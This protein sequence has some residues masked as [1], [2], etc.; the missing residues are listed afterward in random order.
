M[1]WRDSMTLIYFVV[2]A[3]IFAVIGW[4]TLSPAIKWAAPAVALGF[5]SVGLGVNSLVLVNHTDR[6]IETMNEALKSIKQ[7]QEEI[8]KEQKEQSS[9]SSKIVPTLQAFS[10][11]YLDYLSKQKSGEEQQNSNTDDIESSKE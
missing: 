10:Q 3:V 9:S 2:A 1:N 6:K 11:L 8:Q 7:L 4:F 5:I